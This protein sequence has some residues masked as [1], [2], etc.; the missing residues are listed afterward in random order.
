MGPRAIVTGAAGLIGRYLVRTAPRWAP[1]LEVQGLSRAKLELTETL[2]ME[3]RIRAL[4]PDL[5]I[6][7]AALSRINACEQD[8]DLARRIN[9]E[10]TVHLAHLCNEIPFVFLSS[11][12]VFDGARGWYREGDEANP[13][14][15][16][17]KTKLEA[18]Q[19]V[20]QNP[21]HTVVRIVLTAGTSRNGDR[22][23]VEDM[24]RTAK[25][26][27]NVTLYV[28]EF[29]C[30]LPAVVIARAI[31]ELARCERPGLYHLG[32]SE[33]L[34]RWEMG[35]ALLPWYPELEGRLERG[36]AQNHTGAP[37]PA[38]LSLR[39]DKLQGLL[40]FRIPGF[41][42]WLAR[43]SQRGRDLWDYASP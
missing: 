34:S 21:R 9:V 6:H 24:C 1:D 43:R 20:L 8:P 3:A 36:S 28:D 13:V 38:D 12:E 14:N 16:Y 11:G 7:C 26:G 40:S 29:R 32:G 2:K 10:A 15:F 30:P 5:L 41:C 18:E 25:A 23:F 39:C 17:G 22:S 19:R 35:Q 42:E 37:R 27:K 4:K 33:R 31:W